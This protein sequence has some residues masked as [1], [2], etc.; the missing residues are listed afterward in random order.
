MTIIQGNQ[1]KQLIAQILLNSCLLTQIRYL[2]GLLVS[3]RELDPIIFCRTEICCSLIVHCLFLEIFCLLLMRKRLKRRDKFPIGFNVVQ[4]YFFNLHLTEIF[5][6]EEMGTLDICW[7]SEHSFFAP[8]VLTGD[9]YLMVRIT[10]SQGKIHASLLCHF[11][12]TSVLERSPC[13][14]PKV[15]S[16]LTAHRWPSQ[17]KFHMVLSTGTLSS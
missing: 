5:P 1:S 16:G 17:G 14:F 2:Y 7:I 8:T 10:T 9:I 3:P 4:F 11:A 12:G 6:A 13:A 15:Q